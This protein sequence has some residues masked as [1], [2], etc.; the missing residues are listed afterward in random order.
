MA[1][2]WSA[3]GD[4]E[5]G[6]LQ[7]SSVGPI[8]FPSGPFGMGTH[9]AGPANDGSIDHLYSPAY[10]IPAGAS[11]RL[12]FDHWMCAYDGY[13]GGA[14]FI[15]TDNSTWTHFDPGN[16]WYD[17]PGYTWGSGTLASV[18][19]FDGSN[20][21]GS[22]FPYCLGPRNSW[23]TK[24]ADL[25]CLLYTSPSPRDQRGSRMPSSA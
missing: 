21:Q 22:T 13:A 14:V 20:I 15:S 24:V 6:A 7:T 9:L 12:T 19:I 1:P 10:N 2:G 25:T 8:S 18:G 17:K 16:N 11:A 23:E 4:W 3:T 5:Y